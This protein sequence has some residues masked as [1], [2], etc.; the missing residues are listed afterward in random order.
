MQN[1]ETDTL[2][3]PSLEAVESARDKSML[4]EYFDTEGISAEDLEHWTQMAPE[5]QKLA[6]VEELAFEDKAVAPASERKGKD[7]GPSMESG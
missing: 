5:D 3:R 2:K 7:L 4:H 6:H 1:I